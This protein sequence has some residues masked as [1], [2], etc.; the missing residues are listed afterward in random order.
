V[1]DYVEAVTIYAHS[2]ER[3][4]RCVRELADALDARGIDI[5][6]EGLLP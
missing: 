2:E 6:I 3:A 1:Q 5:F 4:Q